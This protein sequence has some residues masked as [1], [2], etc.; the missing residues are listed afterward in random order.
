MN[1][2]IMVLVIV[3]LALVAV[4]GYLLFFSDELDQ[5][6]LGQGEQETPDLS[7]VFEESDVTPPQLPS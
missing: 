1:A 3:V 4:I 5:G 2:M 7:G 6:F